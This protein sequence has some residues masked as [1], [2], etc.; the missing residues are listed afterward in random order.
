M[1]QYNEFDLLMIVNPRSTNAIVRN[2][3][4]R[5]KGNG[6]RILT[7]IESWI[8]YEVSNILVILRQTAF[9]TPA[10]ERHLLP[11]LKNGMFPAK[12]P[13]IGVTKERKLESQSRWLL[14][15]NSVS[16]SLKLLPNS[17][18]FLLVQFVQPGLC[19]GAFEMVTVTRKDA[20]LCP[21]M[22]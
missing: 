17:H 22:Y 6:K 3:V 19:R 2:L 8:S 9:M 5:L 20:V 16:I 1:L 14:L 12:A 21:R 13:D 15:S 18:W 11:H 4:S 7:Q 10:L